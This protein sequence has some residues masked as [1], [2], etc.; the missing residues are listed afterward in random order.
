MTTAGYQNSPA[1]SSPLRV[2]EE[3]SLARPE[4]VWGVAECQEKWLSSVPP[5]AI[6]PTA[7]RTSCYVL[8]LQFIDPTP[9]FIPS[10]TPVCPSKPR[11]NAT[12]SW[13]EPE[14]PSSWIPEYIHFS[15]I[16]AS[17]IFSSR[18]C[19]LSSTLLFP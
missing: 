10:F 13:A 8:L 5:N 15:I 3:G 19:H 2:K 1:S 9:S 14:L 12:D 7:F 6:F 4:P 16:A 18:V 17:V 11:A